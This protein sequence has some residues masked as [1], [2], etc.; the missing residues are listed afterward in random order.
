MAIAAKDPTSHAAVALASRAS[1]PAH[2]LAIARRP[3]REARVEALE[4]APVPLS[5]IC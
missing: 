3:S 1:V 5:L 2:S 4:V